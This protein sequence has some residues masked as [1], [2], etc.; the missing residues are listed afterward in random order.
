MGKSLVSCFF[1]SQCRM[2]ISLKFT[3]LHKQCQLQKQ[4]A[5]H[6]LSVCAQPNAITGLLVEKWYKKC[7]LLA[8]LAE[9]T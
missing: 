4:D 2:K 9:I 5:V 7:I 8:K 1:D 6:K 3:N